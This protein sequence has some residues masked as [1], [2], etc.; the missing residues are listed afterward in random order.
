MF[1]TCVHF[2]VTK[3]STHFFVIE[4][5]RCVAKKNCEVHLDPGQSKRDFVVS[6][7]IDVEILH[8][9]YFVWCV[10][11]FEAQATSCS[12]FETTHG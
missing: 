12:G 5:L 3:H 1:Y 11:P 9:S 2:H 7:N 8:K 10:I 6:R 4:D